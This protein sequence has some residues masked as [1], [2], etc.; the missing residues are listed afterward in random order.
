[1]SFYFGP[2]VCENYYYYFYYYYDCSAFNE[3]ILNPKRLLF[4]KKNRG[5]HLGWPIVS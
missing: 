4:L 1:M 5:G 3:I 2:T